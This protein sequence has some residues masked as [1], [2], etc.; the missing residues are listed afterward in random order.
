MTWFFS[1][2]P[3]CI[4]FINMYSMTIN[5][6]EAILH[7]IFKHTHVF[8]PFFGFFRGFYIYAL[9]KH[10]FMENTGEIDRPQTKR[11]HIM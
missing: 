1:C 10:L 8:T 11:G 3:Q 4:R 6:F 7:T 9:F 5:H 2:F